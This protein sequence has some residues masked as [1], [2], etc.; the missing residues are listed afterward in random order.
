MDLRGHSRF[1]KISI[2]SNTITYRVS[3]LFRCP[4]KLLILLKLEEKL[5]FSSYVLFFIWKIYWHFNIF[6]ELFSL[7]GYIWSQLQPYYSN[8]YIACSQSEWWKKI[9]GERVSTYE[10]GNYITYF[11]CKLRVKTWKSK[12]YNNIYYVHAIPCSPMLYH[13]HLILLAMLFKI[14]LCPSDKKFVQFCY[15]L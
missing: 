14:H 7:K 10:Y 1:F 9:N 15:W 5:L 3:L 2:K 13:Y 4:M 12:L 8:I 6:H 11:L